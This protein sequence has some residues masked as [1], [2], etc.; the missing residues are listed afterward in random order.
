M[1][2]CTLANNNMMDI[3]GKIVVDNQKIMRSEDSTLA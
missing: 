2:I 1:N 3:L